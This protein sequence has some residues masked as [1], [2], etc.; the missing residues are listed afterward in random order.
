M[1]QLMER[2]SLG[3]LVA[4]IGVVVAVLLAMTGSAR[5]GPPETAQ[6]DTRLINS[7][8]LGG[9]ARPAPTFP[10]SA[11]ILTVGNAESMA[12][13][14]LPSSIIPQQIVTRLVSYSTWQEQWLGTNPVNNLIGPVWVVAILADGVTTEMI[15]KDPQDEL[16]SESPTEESPIVGAHF[17]WDAN[18]GYLI[19]YGALK[20]SGTPSITA[21]LS[22]PNE[23]LVITSATDLP[24]SP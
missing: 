24:S 10:P 17:S 19:G 13:Q 4:T 22:L 3:I 6:G 15:F 11:P 18:G 12:L 21:A 14:Q 20:Q 23:S 16:Y 8:F 2:V 5:P 9:T 1:S 7:V